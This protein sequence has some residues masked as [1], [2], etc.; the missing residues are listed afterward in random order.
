MEVAESTD[1]GKKRSH[2]EDSLIVDER[3]G[4]FIVADG[5]GGHLSGEIASRMAVEVA[6]DYLSRKI[7]KNIDA[8]NIVRI[9]KTALNNAHEAVKI[10]S[11]GDMTLKGM[12][13]TLVI[14][15]IIDDSAFIAHAGDSRAYLIRN[16]IRQITTDH[17][18]GNYLIRK[19]KIP[20]EKV[21]A[22]AWHTITQAVG[23]SIKFQPQLKK[24]SL[25]QNDV[26]L[27]CSDGL[28][29]MLRD[30]EI[31]AIIENDREDGFEKI[32]DLLV[33]A[34]NRKGG[35]DNISVVIVKHGVSQIGS[36]WRTS[37]SF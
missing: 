32:A 37:L 5:M 16:D 30:E 3:R 33:E 8:K 28:T 17:S 12:G 7:D 18:L 29:D 34:A 13:T 22:R 2:N 31:K 1:P 11:D 26:L 23:V 21:P 19:K 10:S 14:M 20:K 15:V 27:L 35:R 25:E 9:L 36:F 24:I 4:I 6:Y